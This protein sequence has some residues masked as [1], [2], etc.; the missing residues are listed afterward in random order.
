[1]LVREAREADIGEIREIFEVVYGGDYP[2]HEVFDEL[3]LKRSIFGD[4]VL[5][6]VAED[7]TAGRIAG[8]GSVMLDFGAHSDL[9]GEFGRLAVRPEYRRQHVGHLLMERRLDAIRDRL[10]VGLVVARTV[11]PY[12]QQISLAHGFAPVGFLPL[13]HQFRRRESFALLARYF[14]DALPLRRNNPRLIPEACDLANLVMPPAGVPA[15]F[16]VDDGATPYPPGGTFQSEVLQAEGYPALLRIERG[17]IRHREIFGPMRLDYGFFRLAARQTTYLLA[18]DGAR[19]VGAVGLAVDAAERSA[20]VFEL[21]ASTDEVARF[22]LEAM[23]AQCQALD[24]EYVEAD[25]SAYAPR[26]QRTLLE[27]GFLPVAYVPAMVFHDVERLDIVKMARLKGAADVGAV[28]LAPAVQA[29]AD[30]VLQGFSAARVAPRM[31]RAIGEVPLFQGMSEEQALRVAGA[32][33]VAAAPAGTTLFE[34]GAAADRLYVVLDGELTI[35]APGAAEPLGAVTTGETVGEVS[36]L[37]GRSHSA[38]ARAARDTEIAMLEA[39]LL[40]DL[41]RRRPDIGV[42]IYRNLARGLGDK[43]LRS[44]HSR[45]DRDDRALRRGLA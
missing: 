27:L 34:A 15:D 5:I 10:H 42:I 4:D 39:G 24:L 9:V 28:A 14:G 30:I 13:K 22:L 20:R 12:A 3:W 43:L 7:T 29:V 6:L 37:A 16:I 21:I 23:S 45:R 19:T 31:A 17:R 33:R 2:H 26:M 35:S 41:I 38:T 11:H 36:V 44:D 25:V 18:R 1:M 8:T 40:A 32:C